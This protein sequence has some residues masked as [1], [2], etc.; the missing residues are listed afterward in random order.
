[1]GG[2]P[3][4]IRDKLEKVINKKAAAGTV[5]V[6]MQTMLGMENYLDEVMWSMLLERHRSEEVRM[7]ELA[8]WLYRI[9]LSHPKETTVQNITA[10]FF[11]IT[12]GLQAAMAMTRDDKLEAS[13]TFKAYIKNLRDTLPPQ[14]QHTVVFPSSPYEWRKDCP[15]AFDTVFNRGPPE[16]SSLQNFDVLRI[17]Q[18]WPMRGNKEGDRIQPKSTRP[19]AADLLRQA[20]DPLRQRPQRCMP[21]ISLLNDHAKTA[22]PLAILDAGAALPPIRGPS[23]SAPHG[24]SAANIPPP[25]PDARDARDVARDDA[26]K[27]VDIMDMD[28][29]DLVK[30]HKEKNKK[31]K[32]R[33][34]A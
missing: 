22:T 25:P 3:T 14:P 9:G 24:A 13:R 17:L 7:S 28:V 21:G 33:T 10:K 19:S 23:P 8:L 4:S 15:R 27:A 31:K 29:F 30:Q 1:M 18:S 12:R 32:K 34:S 16:T 20:P 26:R 6:Y 2:W 11:L 5:V